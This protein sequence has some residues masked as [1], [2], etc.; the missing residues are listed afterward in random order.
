L[1]AS[2]TAFLVMSFASAASEIVSAKFSASYRGTGLRLAGVRS[3]DLR[4]P[5]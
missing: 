1:I 4:G 3:F 5:V 2:H